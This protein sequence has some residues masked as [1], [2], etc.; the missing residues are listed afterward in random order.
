MKASIRIIQLPVF[1]HLVA[2]MLTEVEYW[3]LQDFLA[4]RPDAG[5]LLRGCRGL[6]KL[7][8]AVERD[9]KGKSGG[10]RVIYYWRR[11][12]PSTLYFV[13]MFR[14]S[15]QEN[16]TKGQQNVL[17]RLVSEELKDE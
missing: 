3:E 7:R 14:K 10:V 16:L 11:M 13:T 2:Q 12:D 5:T 9:A 17:A 8:W 1:T 6:R 15:K 4:A